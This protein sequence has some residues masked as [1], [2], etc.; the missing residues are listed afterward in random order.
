MLARAYLP[1]AVWRCL[2]A[3]KATSARRRKQLFDF[4]ER[5]ARNKSLKSLDGFWGDGPPKG[6]P[7]DNPGI[8]DAMARSALRLEGDDPFVS[9]LRAAFAKFGLDPAD[10]S[11]WRQLLM[12]FAFVEFGT[13]PRRKRGA[14]KK[15]NEDRLSALRVAAEEIKSNCPHQRVADSEIAR[16]LARKGKFVS[17]KPEVGAGR[18]GLRKALRVARRS[19]GRN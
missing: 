17:L 9:A 11:S 18:E 13:N 16:L 14:P 2:M 19:L 5:Q 3:K 10:P 1:S 7:I 12:M 6:S 15:W 8:W 4:A